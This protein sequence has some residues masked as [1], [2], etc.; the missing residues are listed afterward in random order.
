MAGERVRAENGVGPFHPHRVLQVNVDLGVKGRPRV[1][2]ERINTMA[3]SREKRRPALQDLG[4]AGFHI[5]R[6]PRIHRIS[7]GDRHYQT[8]DTEEQQQ[9]KCSKT[10][11]HTLPVVRAHGSVLS[12]LV[13]MGHHVPFFRPRRSAVIASI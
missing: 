12:F 2:V 1:K 6:R 13:C 5:D 3:E 11:C 4:S 10:V 9:G 7:Q 8:G